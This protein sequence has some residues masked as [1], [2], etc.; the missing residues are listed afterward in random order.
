MPSGGNFVVPIMGE[1][2][3]VQGRVVAG[4]AGQLLVH[5]GVSVLVDLPRG[6]DAVDLHAGPL[7]VG[8]MVN[9]VCLPGARFVPVG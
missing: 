8:D 3:I 9:V 2:R 5:A 7:E 6:D 4:D 1:T